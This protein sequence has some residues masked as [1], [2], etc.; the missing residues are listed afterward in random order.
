M[1]DK[2][3]DAVYLHHIHDAIEEIYAIVGERDVD[4][5]M[6]NHQVY[7]SILYLMVVIGEASGKL[8][9]EFKSE[10]IDIPWEKVKGM[11]NILIH[12]YAGVSFEVV[13]KTVQERLPELKRVAVMGISNS[14]ES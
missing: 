6:K 4:A 8:S 3:K 13:W 7:Y 1:S 11:R 9:Q 10:H 2:E 14:D 12:E 5:V